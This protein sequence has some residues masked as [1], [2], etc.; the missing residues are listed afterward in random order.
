MLV[1]PL[2]HTVTLRGYV[3]LCLLIPFSVTGLPPQSFAQTVPTPDGQ[4]F[5]PA[6]KLGVSNFNGTG[7][8]MPAVLNDSMPSSATTTSTATPTTPMELPGS[9]AHPQTVQATPYSVPI[10]PSMSV[11]ANLENTMMTLPDNLGSG[12]NQSIVTPVTGYQYIPSGAVPIGSGAQSNAP[13]PAP[14]LNGPDGS[15]TVT[16]SPPQSFEYADPVADQITQQLN[17]APIEQAPL[18]QEVVRWYHYPARWM[19]GWDSN[20]EFGIDGSDGNAETLALQTGLELK[21]QTDAYTLLFDFDYRQAS[22]RDV[23][24]ENNGRFNVDYDRLLGDSAWSAFGKFGMEWD[25]FKAFDLRL[26]LNGGAGYHWIRDDSTSL[27]TRFGAG[28]SQE[29]GAPN[30]D[31]IPEAVFG[32]DAERQITSRQKIKAKVDYFPSWEDF[33]DYRLVFDASWEILLDGSD[34]LSLKLAATDR[35]DSTPQGAEANDL[36]YSLLLLYKF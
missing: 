21:R 6:W 3:F 33:S 29:I 5:I 34:N 15:A 7:Y 19:K 16:S 31:W 11:R 18:Q 35:Y 10:D 28:A 22:S 25:E 24:T 2:K 4:P 32:I 1:S 20:A 30:D 12:A 26:N 9:F 27:V 13:L 8:D 14:L 23:T 17:S 36:Y